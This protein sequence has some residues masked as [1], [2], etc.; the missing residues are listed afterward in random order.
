MNMPDTLNRS[1]QPATRLLTRPK[2][3]SRALFVGCHE[4]VIDHRGQEYRM[5]IASNGELVLTK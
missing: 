3:D 2:I 1:S 4:I 5:R